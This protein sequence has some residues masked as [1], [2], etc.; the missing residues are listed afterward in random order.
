MSKYFQDNFSHLT[1]EGPQKT[2]NWQADQV[3]IPYKDSKTG[4]EYLVNERKPNGPQGDFRRAPISFSIRPDFESRPDE[5]ETRAPEPVVS[6]ADIELK[7][8]EREQNSVK[9]SM[10]MRPTNEP[11]QFDT[12]TDRGE[13]TVDPMG[14]IRDKPKNVVGHFGTESERP[15][16]LPLV[17]ENEQ[18]TVQRA[19]LGNTQSLTS[20]YAAPL[21]STDAIEKKISTDQKLQSLLSNA[22]RG[23]QALQSKSGEKTQLADRLL[24]PEA[25]VLA[26]S[27]MDAGLLKPWDAPKSKGTSDRPQRPDDIAH[28]V[29][30]RA[31]QSLIKGPLAHDIQDLPKAERDDMS[32]ALG[33]TILNALVGA[34]EQRGESGLLADRP[35]VAELKSSLAL[36]ISPSILNGLVHPELLSDRRPK[37]LASVQR[38]T[39]PSQKEISAVPNRHT[40]SITEKPEQIKT[41]ESRPLGKF[42]YGQKKNLF[43]DDSENSRIEVRD[44][45][46]KSVRNENEAFGA[47][48]ELG[49]FSSRSEV[50]FNRQLN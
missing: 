20:N 38:L 28:A 34:P 45:T 50:S 18:K 27:I 17:P 29:G 41:V 2:I 9:M 40:V 33:R 42:N 30:S 44:T 22:F 16:H 15:K 36:S 31:L 43:F 37:D 1:N 8:R 7:V 10:A 39:G 19:E 23:L 11:V 6:E 48:T 46:R 26:K 3:Q 4:A 13:Y 14:Q 24:G 25:T 21:R 5:L 47:R 12:W 49:S 32:K 35:S